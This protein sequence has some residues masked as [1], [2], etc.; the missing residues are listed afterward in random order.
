MLASCHVDSAWYAVVLVTVCA[1]VTVSHPAISVSATATA[2]LAQEISLVGWQKLV[3]LL[4]F[5]IFLFLHSNAAVL[6]QA[7]GNVAATR[8][9]LHSHG[10][11]IDFKQSVVYSS[12][13][14][15]EV[16]VSY[17]GVACDFTGIIPDN[18]LSLRASD[19]L[20]IMGRFLT[21]LFHL[22]IAVGKP[23]GILSS[24]ISA[25]RCTSD[26]LH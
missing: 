22:H 13:P 15:N 24:F 6:M 7:G 21:A 23:I 8:Y 2:Q 3:D 25:T 18:I 4:L 10:Q 1:Y 19:L 16:T 11:Y 17:D 14:D 26:I 5:F 9:G 20:N 12:S